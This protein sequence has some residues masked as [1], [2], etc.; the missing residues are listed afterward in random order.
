MFRVICSADNGLANIYS[1]TNRT[2]ITRNFIKRMASNI[3]YRISPMGPRTFALQWTVF[4]CEKRDKIRISP[5]YSSFLLFNFYNF[6]WCTCANS[7]VKWASQSRSLE[8]HRESGFS[9]GYAVPLQIKLFDSF[10]T[11]TR[12]LDIPAILASS[13]RINLINNLSVFAYLIKNNLS[14]FFV[15][16]VNYHE[17]FFFNSLEIQMTTDRSDVIKIECVKSLGALRF[18]VNVF[19]LFCLFF[20]FFFIKFVGKVIAGKNQ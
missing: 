5:R 16:I 18:G 4:K 13:I 9:V 15:K 17:H 1:F 6:T 8:S 14:R 11:L 2:I 19:R 3:T 20:P 7:A 12:R 10:K